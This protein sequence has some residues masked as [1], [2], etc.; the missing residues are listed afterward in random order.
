MTLPE[1]FSRTFAAAFPD[2]AGRPVLVALSGGSDSVAL[3][4]LLVATR[5]RTGCGVHAA[6]VHHHLRGAEADGDAAFCQT[7][8]GSLAVPLAVLHLDPAPPRGASPE[9]WW[10][11]ERYRLLEAARERAGC[12]ATATAH[13]LDDQAETV[14]L[15]LLR[16]AGVRGVAGI[17]PRRGAVIRP[18]LGARREELRAWLR[19]RGASWREDTSN[20]AAD[21]P[22]AH[23]RHLLLPALAAAYP[24]VAEHLGAFAAMLAEDDVFL[25]RAM[26]AAAARPA[27]GRPVE[28]TPV[29]ALPPALRR[30]WVLALA[31]GLPLA[32]PPSRAQLTAAEQVI[33]GGSPAAIDLG[34]RWVLRRRGGMVHLSPPPLPPFAPVA[35]TLP[36]T[37]VLPGGFVARIGESG[38][39]AATFAA[40]VSRRAA[41]GRLA[42]RP[43]APGERWPGPGGRRLATLLAAAGVPAEWR[44]AWPLLEA[45]G[46]ILWVPAVN[47]RPEPHEPGVHEIGLELEVPW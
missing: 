4:H 35:A 40:V 18:L 38:G 21:R 25:S 20:L 26:A 36:S 6:H 46:T 19:E 30:R 10:R 2:V 34:R 23:V 13:T 9:A 1:T 32:E 43:A 28:R 37:T 44:R 39:G 33:L 14:L 42:W 41:A 47:V 45:G 7:L 22:R 3:L 17:R 5:E 29:A 27:V 31:D 12:A 8:C 11:S 15:K 16:G 24:R